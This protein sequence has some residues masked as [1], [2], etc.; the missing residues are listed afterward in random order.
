[1]KLPLLPI[2][3]KP[4]Y[5]ISRIRENYGDCVIKYSLKGVVVNLPEDKE[6][7]FAVNIQ[8]FFGPF[9]RETSSPF[10]GIRDGEYIESTE[11]I[12]RG[13]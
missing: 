4:K 5:L 6:P 3:Y 9:F 7:C 2:Y 1:M 12:S 10:F 11:G 13:E 8:N